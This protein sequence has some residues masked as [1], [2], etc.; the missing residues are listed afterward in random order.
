MSSKYEIINRIIYSFIHSFIRV[1]SKY[2]IINRII[3]SFIPLACAECDD[4]LL[5]SGASSIPLCYVFFLPPFSTNYSSILPHFILPSI[6][7]SPCQSCC[8]QIHILCF[9][10]EF[11]FLPFSELA[12]TNVIS[13]TLLSLLKWV[14]FKQ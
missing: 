13:L 9:W 12:K 2:E 5:F 7:W 14:F 11:Y 10:G 1:S 3:H 4:S 8:F 6:S